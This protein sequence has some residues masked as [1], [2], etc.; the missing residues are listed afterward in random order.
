MTTVTQIVSRS[1]RLIKVLD[2]VEAAEAEDMET[3]MV[4]LNAMVGRW[5]A[6]GMALGWAAVT[7]PAGTIP[8]PPEAEEAVAY[9][10]AVKLAPEYDVEP[11][12]V[13]VQEARDGLAALRRDCLVS[14]PLVQESDLPS[15]HGLWNITTD[16]PV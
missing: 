7:S 15:S 14:R 12:P 4:A 11:S 16:E 6:N 1:L 2:P 3:A 9:N 13:V 8:L 5:E 10:L